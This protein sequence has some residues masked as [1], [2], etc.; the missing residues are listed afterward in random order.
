M[1]S[2]WNCIKKRAE[3]APR[4][5]AGPILDSATCTAWAGRRRFVLIAGVA[6]C[7]SCTMGP[8]FTRPTAIETKTYRSNAASATT[9]AHVQ[10]GKDLPGRWW[11]L[12]RC[13]PLT[14]LI[15]KAIKHNPDLQSAQAALLQ[16]QELATAKQGALWPSLDASA[17]GV[18]QQISGAQ[19][20][21]PGGGSSVFSLYNASVQVSYTLDVFGAIRR[22]IEVLSAQAEYQQFQL[23]GIFLSLAGNIVTTAIQEAS[24][25]AQLQA[26]DD[27]IAA[28]LRQVNLIEQQVALG[29]AAQAAVLAQQAALAQT[30]ATL[31]ALQQQLAQTRHRLSVL[32]GDLPSLEPAGRFQLDDLT[33][34][35]PLPV[36]LPARLVAQ[37]P[38]IRA[39]EA[40]L[41][42]ASAQIGVVIASVLP[43]LTLNADLGSIATKASELFV[44]GSGIWSATASA[45]QPIFHGGD[46]THKR[47]AAI[48]SYQQAAA[49]YQSTVLQA[50]QDVAD[51]L[52]ALEFDA[53][54]LKTQ[55]TAEAT[56]QESLALLQAQYR[57]GAASYLAMLTAEKELHAAR[58]GRIKAQSARLADSAALFQAL[59]GAWWNRDKLAEAV[60]SAHKDTFKPCALL[61]CLS[62][63]LP[64]GK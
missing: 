50:F 17:D 31:P 36:S 1:V 58:L 5:P 48:A 45:L 7:A 53:A 12:Y 64:T 56:A 29:A 30:R 40:V 61:D 60:L 28:Q 39:Q 42:A 26:T 20:G 27:M 9:S 21:N 41:H 51:V 54:A 59:G 38:D 15:D 23:E 13:Q 14:A 62:A 11:A 47:T 52:A 57:L 35:D 34:P 32:V 3:C 44:P 8:D 63:P 19:F 24:L 6:L 25:R 46:F 49:Q 18:R 4:R 22:Q 33:L 2:A 10:F 43:N 37:R 55:R 16:A